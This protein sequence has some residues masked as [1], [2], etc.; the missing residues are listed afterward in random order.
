MPDFSERRCIWREKPGKS[1]AAD[2]SDGWC[3]SSS[4]AIAKPANGATTAGLSGALYLAAEVALAQHLIKVVLG[5]NGRAEITLDEYLDRWL[6][7]AAKQRLRE[8][9][10]RS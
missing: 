10:Y 2:G 6:E 9:S 5:L 4:D 7:T 8:K 3:A 1:W